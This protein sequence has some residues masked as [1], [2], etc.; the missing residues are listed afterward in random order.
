MASV[1]SPAKRVLQISTDATAIKQDANNVVVTMFG[2]ANQ[3]RL[4][5]TDKVCFR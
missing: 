5:I 2:G 3:W 1:Y 4:I